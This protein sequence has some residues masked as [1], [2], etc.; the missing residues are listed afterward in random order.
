M[1]DTTSSSRPKTAANTS[2]DVEFIREGV[3]FPDPSPKPTTAPES[4]SEFKRYLSE[5]ELEKKREAQF[6][7]TRRY[8]MPSLFQ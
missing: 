8:F 3:H 7:P 1:N 6:Q 5:K 4:K 2:S